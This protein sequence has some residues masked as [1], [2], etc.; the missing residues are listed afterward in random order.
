MV[1]IS[2]LKV[3]TDSVTNTCETCIKFK[4]PRPHPIVTFPLASSFNEVV[5]MDLKSWQSYQLLVMVDLD[6]RF[7]SAAVL[8]NKKLES[9]ASALF[10][11]WISTFG[12]PRKFLSDNGG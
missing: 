1:M 10:S 5:A 9:V 6:T 8:T 7:C 3:A 11:E 4:K 2:Y 12:A